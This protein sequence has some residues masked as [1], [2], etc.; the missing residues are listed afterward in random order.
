MTETQNLPRNTV[1]SALSALSNLLLLV[2]VILAARI[3]GDSDYGKFSLAL[4]VASIFEMPIDFGL[5]TLTVKD[6][7]RDRGLAAP[8]LHSIL[9][10]KILLS[11]A[12]ML[13]LIPTAHLLTKSADAR[14]AVYAMG[15]AIV[16]RSSKATAHAFFSAY[17][18]FDLVL[19]TTYSE[20]MIIVL[21]CG[22]MLFGTKAL[23]PFAFAFAFARIPDLVFSYWLLH[24]R[25]AR[26]G[27]SMNTSLIR[28]IQ[29]K[30]LPFGSLNIVRVMYAYIGTVILGVLRTSAE[31]GWYSAGYRIYEGLTMFPYILCAVL[32]PRLSHLYVADR[33]RHAELSARGM[34]YLLILSLPILVCGWLLAPRILAA[35]FGPAYLQG[36]PA[37][38]MLFAASVFMFSNWLLN[39]ILVSTDKQG[40]VLKV[41]AIGLGISIMAH[42][43]LI[44][45]YGATGA[46]M[47]ALFAEVCVFAMFMWVARRD[48]VRTEALSAAWRPALACLCTVGMLNWLKL[49]TPFP[50]I[51]TFAVSYLGLLLVLRTFDHRE[52]SAVKGVFSSNITSRS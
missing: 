30:A 41:S 48:V 32:L 37:L 8:Y 23:I 3:L 19:L 29:V 6:V 2:L 10:W 7:A 25:I 15:L 11:G 47:A 16:L 46:G 42:F 39:T 40:A 43:A 35:V 33:E 38:R 36:V 4:A 12:V 1:F 9:P 44:R 20:R 52:W 27:W 51:L 14:I 13:A 5:S 21:V 34:K 17:E 50:L 26:L 31:V 22:L 24:G 18:R 49:D 28:R 45:P